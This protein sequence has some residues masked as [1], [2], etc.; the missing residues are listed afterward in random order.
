MITLY[1]FLDDI[2]CVEN[3]TKYRQVFIFII[4][5]LE[6]LFMGINDKRNK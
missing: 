6:Q 3:K 4:R 2:L 1:L 5:N